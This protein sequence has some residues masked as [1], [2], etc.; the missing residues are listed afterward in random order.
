[1]HLGVE[2]T[3]SST[4]KQHHL[5]QR[6][7]VV[8]RQVTTLAGGSEAGTV[9][10]AGVGAR[11]KYPSP[12]AL[13]ERGRLLVAEDGQGVT[14]RMVDASL[15][16]SAWMGPVDAAAETQEEKVRSVTDSKISR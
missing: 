3:E 4:N 15:A 14:L 12:L 1:M 8:G 10:G 11:F 2:V 6:K 9:D 7:T 13:D 16:P 5:S